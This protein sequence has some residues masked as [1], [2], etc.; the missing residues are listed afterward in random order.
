MFLSAFCVCGSRAYAAGPGA[1]QA[2]PTPSGAP[3]SGSASSSGAHGS[4]SSP[5]PGGHGSGGQSGSGAPGGSGGYGKHGQAQ[6]EGGG[7]A[8]GASHGASGGGGGGAGG[9]AAGGSAGGSG[10]SGGDARSSGIT[11]ASYQREF[12]ILGDGDKNLNSV[13]TLG[14]AEELE[15]V[16]TKTQSG[17][18]LWTIPEPS[19]SIDEFGQRCAADPKSVGAVVI[20][21]YSGFAT[22]FY[23]LYQS[24]TTS[25]VLFA[26]LLTCGQSPANAPAPTLIGI[27]SELPGSQGTPWVIRRSQTSIPLLSLAAIGTYLSSASSSS[28]TTQLTLATV[29]GSLFSGAGSRDIPGYSD[30]IRLRYTAKHIGDDLYVGM[31]DGICAVVPAAGTAPDDMRNQLC[32]ELGLAPD[33]SPPASVPTIP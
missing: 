20:T 24:E 17:A 3:P 2:S 28:K 30:P 19:W 15:K 21:Y 11:I 26:Q 32:R 27:V 31:K 12:Y 8:H 5:E 23:L 29:S 1:P 10:P 33:Q 18:P 25:T 7:S 4:G 16:F 13:L 6:A 22:H 14:V 9:G